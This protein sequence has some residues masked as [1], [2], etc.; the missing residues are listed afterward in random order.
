M[1]SATTDI[2]APWPAF[3]GKGNVVDL[4]WD[5]FGEVDNLIEPFCRTAVVTLRR[6][7]AKAGDR[8]VETINDIDCYISNVWRAIVADPEAVAEYADYPVS[9]ADLHSRH[10]WLVGVEEAPPL[11]PEEWDQEV[12]TRLA[13]LAGYARQDGSYAKAFREKLRTDPDYYDARFA[14]WWVWGACMWIGSGWCETPEAADWDQRPQPEDSGGRGITG[15]HNKRPKIA[16]DNPG[17]IGTGV[18][19]CPND[20]MP[21]EAPPGDPNDSKRPQ[22]HTGNSQY[23]RGVHAKGPAEKL[24][25]ISQNT[26]TGCRGVHSGISEKIPMSTRP[27]SRGGNSTLVHAERPNDGHRPQLADAF[28]IGRGVNSGWK[29]GSCQARRAWLVNWFEALRDRLRLVRVCCGDWTR[30]CTSPSVTTRLGLTGIFLD[31]PYATSVERMHAWV[32]FLDGKGPEPKAP[33]KAT[34]RV[35]VLYASDKG[36]DVDRL[37]ADV[38]R[39]CRERGAETVMRIAV[40]GYRGEHDPLE[41]LGWTCV[42]WKANGGYSNRGKTANENKA[43]ECIWFSPHCIDPDAT[44]GPLFGF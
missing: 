43:R 24:P 36:S 1:S 33:G 39:Y 22:L 15:V 23:G 27:T 30:V 6:P 13:Y 2:K 14:G 16:G 32:A 35:A 31:P 9:E 12:G 7:P 42:E 3:G 5:R 21:C 20:I 11:V 19:S 8:R 44:A 10:R 17:S 18:H 41:A 38:H 26:S 28:D 25:E 4:V 34:N 37:V 40:C 29:L